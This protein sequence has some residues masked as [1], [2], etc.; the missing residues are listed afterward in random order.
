MIDGDY[1]ESTTTN[2]YG[3]FDFADVSQGSD[4]AITSL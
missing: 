3:E 4:A 1:S 2:A